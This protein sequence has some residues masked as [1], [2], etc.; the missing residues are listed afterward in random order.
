MQITNIL[1][2]FIGIISV[3][4]WVFSWHKSLYIG[5]YAWAISVIGMA[6]T[7]WRYEKLLDQQISAK[8]KTKDRGDLIDHLVE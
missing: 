7:H 4:I 1:F 6:T 2:V 8:Q 3:G 5:Y